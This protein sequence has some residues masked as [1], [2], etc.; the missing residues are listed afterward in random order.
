V[1]PFYPSNRSTFQVHN[2]YRYIAALPLQA[3]LLSKR[4]QDPN[5]GNQGGAGG[6]GGAGVG[7]SGAANAALA[8]AAKASR[9]R[10]A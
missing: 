5:A 7:A 8:R 1:K 4:N 2:L 10:E 3:R 9:D 6:G